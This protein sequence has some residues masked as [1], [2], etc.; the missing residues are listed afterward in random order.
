MMPVSIENKVLTPRR[1][2]MFQAR[3]G[4]I[5]FEKVNKVVKK[6]K[7]KGTSPV[8]AYGEVTGHAH[9]IVAPSFDKVDMVVDTDDLALL[10]SYWLADCFEDY[11]FSG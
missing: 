8:I 4:D 2:N 5:F 1:T 11:H 7:K 9:K 6:G 10:A 3:Q